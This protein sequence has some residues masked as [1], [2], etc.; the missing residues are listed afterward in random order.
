MLREIV[1]GMVLAAMAL[2]AWPVGEPRAAAL[3][4]IPPRGIYEL[5]L[6]ELELIEGDASLEDEEA[7]LHASTFFDVSFLP[8]SDDETIY[9]ERVT[10]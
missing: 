5:E 6:V 2:A 10:P 4:C 3:K 1:P 8:M 9:F 7:R